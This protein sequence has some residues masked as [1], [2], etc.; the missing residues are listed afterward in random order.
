MDGERT[1]AAG[2]EARA[3]L[4]LEMRAIIRLKSQGKMFKMRC[5]YDDTQRGGIAAR[6][7]PERRPDVLSE[8]H[9]SKISVYLKQPCTG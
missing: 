8:V 1:K 3:R 6:S 5:G 9:E 2:V 7:L 4:R